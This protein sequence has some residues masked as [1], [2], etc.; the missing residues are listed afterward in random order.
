METNTVLV[1]QCPE[2][3]KSH[4]SSKYHHRRKDKTVYLGYHYLNRYLRKLYVYSQ[5]QGT[6][7]QML[8]ITDGKKA[9]VMV[10]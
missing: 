10:K 5:L 2:N 8:C 9:E 1:V 3:T 6:C 7:R 4:L